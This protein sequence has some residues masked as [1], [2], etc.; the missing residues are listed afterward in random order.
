MRIYLQVFMGLSSLFGTVPVQSSDFFV[1]QCALHCHTEACGGERDVD[2]RSSISIEGAQG[3]WGKTYDFLLRKE[4]VFEGPL[5]RH[6]EKRQN[7]IAMTRREVVVERETLVFLITEGNGDRSGY[8]LDAREPQVLKKERLS[9]GDAVEMTIFYWDYHKVDGFPFAFMIETK[10]ARET[11]PLVK[12][13]EI[14]PDPGLPSFY[15]RMPKK[16]SRQLLG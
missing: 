12:I 10:V 3:Q 15:F 6:L 1:I 9:D 8:S 14:I 16:S 2:A 13:N 4:A 7:K 11:L 5:F